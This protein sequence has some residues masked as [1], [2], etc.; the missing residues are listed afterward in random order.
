V[1]LVKVP[2]RTRAEGGIGMT[3]QPD[4]HDQSQ[5]T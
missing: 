2:S 1:Q 4:P 3:G 5:A